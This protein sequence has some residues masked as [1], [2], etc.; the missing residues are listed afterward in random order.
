MCVSQLSKLL[1]NFSWETGNFARNYTS[2]CFVFESYESVKLSWD[3]PSGTCIFFQPGKIS[4]NGQQRSWLS[5][6][7]IDHLIWVSFKELGVHKFMAFIAFCFNAAYKTNLSWL[8]SNDL[9]FQGKS[10]LSPLFYCTLQ[11]YWSP[12]VATTRKAKHET[13]KFFYQHA[14]VR[15]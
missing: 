12:I 8:I 10:P 15:S 7:A 4:N 6:L 11:Y 14:V 1:L 5:K 2:C 3:S 13:K 9:V